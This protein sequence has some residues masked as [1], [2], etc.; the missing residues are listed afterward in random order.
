MSLII[1]VY[2]EDRTKQTDLDLFGDEPVNLNLSF[3]EIQDISTRNSAY[4]QSFSLPGSKKNDQFFN[5]YYDVNSSSL[6]FD[7]NKKYPCDLVYNG[8]LILEGNL[9]LNLVTIKNTEKVYSATFYNQIGDLSANIND[10]LLCDLDLTDLDHEWSLSNIQK[11]WNINFY[12]TDT[13]PVNSLDTGLKNGKIIYPFLHLG[14][15]YK[16]DIDGNTIIDTDITPIFDGNG[17]P[18]TYTNNTSGVPFNYFKLAVQVR[19][20]YKR[21]VEDAGYQIESDFFQ[22]SNFNRFYYPLSDSKAGFGLNQR[23]Q[24]SSYKYQVTNNH[25]IIPDS[26]VLT[27][28]PFNIVQN[29]GLLWEPTGNFVQF[30]YNAIWNM[31]IDF[32][33]SAN[34]VNAQYEVRFD[35]YTSSGVYVQNRWISEGTV[36]FFNSVSFNS[37]VD[38]N[39]TSSGL[40]NTDNKYRFNVRAYQPYAIALQSCANNLFNAP[41]EVGQTVDVGQELNCEIKQID[42][43]QSINKWFNLLVIPKPNEPNVLIVEPYS[44]WVGSGEEVDWSQKVDRAK[45]IKVEPTNKL[46]PTTVLYD[47]KTSKDFYNTEYIKTNTFKF[48]SRQA[49]YDT[50]FK[51]KEKKIDGIFGVSQDFPVPNTFWSHPIFYQSKEDEQEDGVIV[52]KLVP[53]KTIPKL[54]YYAKYEVIPVN[55]NPIFI[56]SGSNNYGVTSV[57]MF[58]TITDFPYPYTQTIGGVEQSSTQDITFNKHKAN[59]TYPEGVPDVDLMGDSYESYYQDYLEQLHSSENRL[60]TCQ[61]YLSP[62]EIRDLDFSERIRVDNAIYVINKISGYNLTKPSMAKV[63]LLKLVNDYKPSPNTIYIDLVNCN[64]SLDIIY[65]NL[66]LSQWIARPLNSS[67]GNIYLIDGQCYQGSW[68]NYRDD[69]EYV[70]TTPTF[71]PNGRMHIYF[72]CVECTPTVTT[73]TT[74]AVYEYEIENCL[75]SDRID[76]VGAYQ[77]G[78]GDIYDLQLG[79]N[80]SGCYTVIGFTQ[81]ATLQ[82]GS[83]INTYTDCD[84]CIGVTTTTT[85][86]SPYS[87]VAQNCVTSTQIDVYIGGGI[88]L[89]LGGVYDLTITGQPNGCYTIL[90][91]SENLGS[92]ITDDGQNNYVDCNACSVGPTTTTTTTLTQDCIRY[93]YNFLGMAFIDY[94]DCDGITQRIFGNNP[95]L[96]QWSTNDFC[97]TSIIST[98]GTVVLTS[99]TACLVNPCEFFTAY[100]PDM[101]GEI[102]SFN[103]ISCQGNYTEID[104]YWL[105]GQTSF[106]AQY[107]TLEITEQGPGSDIVYERDC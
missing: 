85:T 55:Y 25:T 76:V 47:V 49:N 19:D 84:D 3:S 32:Y 82:I 34:V 66:N 96:S 62:E 103:F 95:S 70:V 18:G 45:S 106:C 29:D 4:T 89:T 35:E 72:D 100:P 57:P 17:Q 50:D 54:V 42:F 97:A 92:E 61:V 33:L 38:I 16:E 37:F 41:T 5:N 51:S 101:S 58:Q 48:G 99:S 98:N 102:L 9:R 87:Y 91:T 107:Q 63:E 23:A 59:N 15:A 83:V 104:I 67:S 88:Q 46:V 77:L 78:I 44:N 7:V 6:D 28:I 43:I 73:T 14:Y 53:Y 64:N 8:Y 1:R 105:E 40:T 90:G 94:V 26:N 22:T 20:I 74:Q 68:S 31:E 75:T 60:L 10:L 80:L 56:K 27:P 2:N 30:P 12:G 21:I 65:T 11:S 39:I 81:G 71:Y 13:P 69:V 24:A 93:N 86:F 52:N 79:G 36:P